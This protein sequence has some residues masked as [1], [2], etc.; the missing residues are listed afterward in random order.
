LVFFFDEKNEKSLKIKKKSHS[1]DN[2]KKKDYTESVR[3]LTVRFLT[4]E[5]ECFEK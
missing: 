1:L 2:F 3:L 4:K 5:R